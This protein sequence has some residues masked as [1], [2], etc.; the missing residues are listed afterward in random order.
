MT[1]GTDRTH[2][3]YRTYRAYGT[4]RT[5]E[6]KKDLRYNMAMSS[7]PRFPNTQLIVLDLDGT[8]VDTFDDIAAAANHALQLLGR[9]PLSVAEV[10]REVGHGGRNLMKGLLGPGATDAEIETGFQAWR[11]YYGQHPADHARLYPGV[12]ETLQTLHARGI[13][14][15]ALSNKLHALTDA[16][17]RHVGLDTVLDRV[18]GEDLGRPRKPDPA[19]LFEQMATVGVS[20]IA[21]VLVVGD[22]DADMMVARNA[23]VPAIGVS[24]GVTPRERLVELG[25]A[26]V[27]DEFPSLL[28][29]L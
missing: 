14:L 29:Y 26:V 22:G 8:L 19:L 24:Y 4:H 20:D 9:A 3:A 18:Q 13:R 10:K 5:Y 17:A 28:R 23:G 16:V 12:M 7:H 11:E 15:V 27:L 21:R 6:D 25:A 2:T 1:N